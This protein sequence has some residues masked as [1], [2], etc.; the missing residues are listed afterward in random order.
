MGNVRMI[1]IMTGLVTIP[2]FIACHGD[3]TET[4]G[5]GGPSVDAGADIQTGADA[6]NDAGLGG[7]GGEGQAGNGGTATGAGGSGGSTGGGAGMGATGGSGGSTD[8][9]IDTAAPDAI[10]DVMADGIAPSETGPQPSFRDD[11]D[12]T[13]IDSAVWQVAT[14]NEHG[15]KTGKERCYVQNGHLVLEFVY[16]TAYY[17]A[18][19]LFLSSAIQTRETFLYGKWEARLKPA[20]QPGI[21]NSFYTIDWGD[22]SGTKEEIDIEFLTKSFKGSTGQVH[23][24]VHAAGKSSFDTN[25]DVPL[26]FNPSADFH[27][28][29]F[30]ITPT[31]IRWTVDGVVMKEYTYVDPYPFIT[32]PYQLKLNAWSQ[33]AGWVGGPPAANTVCK[34]YIDWIQFTP[35]P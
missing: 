14:W 13:E 25:P 19:G 20:E 21:L 30:E 15:G 17:Q 32:S 4:Q 10:S 16:D 3:E 28:Y 23:Y 26:A 29:G 9:S 18:N 34:Y 8:A 2:F 7:S 22:G 24:A 35:Y 31:E 12:G 5:H 11:F 27:I 33:M 6:H 1:R